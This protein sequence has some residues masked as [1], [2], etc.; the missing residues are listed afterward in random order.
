MILW[1][2]LVKTI[3]TLHGVCLKYAYYVKF[4]R[5]FLYFP[6]KYKYKMKM[7]K[8][9]LQLMNRVMGFSSYS[10][11][12]TWIVCPHQ[13]MKIL[14]YFFSRAGICT[15]LYLCKIY[16]YL[17]EFVT[18]PVMVFTIYEYYIFVLWIQKK[19]MDIVDKLTAD[20]CIIKIGWMG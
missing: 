1:E 14:I 3:T 9:S 17:C 7:I 6:K 20:H 18:F 12:C 19:P 5:F 2:L 8:K 16:T 15:G 4:Y 10:V 11:V 13:K